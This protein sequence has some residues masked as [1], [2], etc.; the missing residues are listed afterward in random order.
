VLLGCHLRQEQ[1]FMVA[2]VDQHAVLPDADLPGIHDAAQRRQDGDFVLEAAQFAGRD[3]VEARVFE[4]RHHGH[5][6]Y[7]DV[8]GLDGRDVSD[9]A[10]QIP[11]LID[12]NERPALPPERLRAARGGFVLLP[13]ADRSFHRLPGNL[14]KRTLLRAGE[15][16]RRILG[17]CAGGLDQSHGAVA[18]HPAVVAGDVAGV[19]VM[20]HLG[21]IGAQ[22]LGGD[23]RGNN[24]PAA[25]SLPNSQI[26][27]ARQIEVIVLPDGIQ[28]LVV[29]A[30]SFVVGMVVGKIGAGHDQGVRALDQFR[31]RHAQGAAAI[32]V[33]VSHDN[34]H[35]L[36]RPEQPLQEGQLHL[37]GVLRMVRRRRMAHP[38]KLDRGA[39]LGE[40]SGEV[41]VDG[42]LAERSRVSVAIVHGREIEGLVMRGRN[43]HH[44]VELAALQ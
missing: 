24:G 15:R 33:L 40:F 4:R 35:K 37:Y 26:Q 23:H 42:N 43:H 44:A 21:L 16:E 17:L 13:R 9:A 3:R 19:G 11:V 30:L 20:Q 5:V 1:T 31:Q 22:P 18:H 25:A 32:V 8:E 41:L 12:G 34:R 36:E 38:R 39:G 6:A 27:V 10:A 7:G 28:R 14:E 29:Q 2:G